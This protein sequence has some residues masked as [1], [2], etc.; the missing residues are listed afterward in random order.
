MRNIFLTIE[1]DGTNFHGWQRQPKS[2]NVQGELEKL[3]SKLCLQ[4]IELAGASR[5][6]A[7][8]HA[9]DQKAT[10]SADFDMPLETLVSVTNQWLP[11]DIKIIGAK[12][13]PTAFHARFDA[14]GKKYSYRIINTPNYHVFERRFN[15]VFDKQLL[16]VEKMKEA[17]SYFL[18][19]HDFKPFSA[20]NGANINSTERTINNIRVTGDEDLNILI[21]IEGKAFL[22][23]MVRMMVGSLIDIGM[24][25]HKPEA[26]VEILEGRMKRIGRTA[27]PEGLYLEKVYFEEISEETFEDIDGE[28]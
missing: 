7:G 24:G 18:G 27:G 5:T 11:I 16:D 6:D 20:N 19:T 8:V 28:N 21:E 23:K 17:A 4:K 12:E 2:R 22:Y 25:K 1:Y 26:I 9:R 3:L 10:F 13:L 14:K 15:T